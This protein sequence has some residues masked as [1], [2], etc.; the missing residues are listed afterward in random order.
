MGIVRYVL[1]ICVIILHTSVLT[2][3]DLPLN[4]YGSA[5]VGGFFALSGF[6]LFSSFQKKPTWRHYI[7]RR[8]RRILPPYFFI[9]IVCALSLSSI[10]TLSITEYFSDKGFWSYLAANLSFLNFLHPELPGVF[11]GP[12]FYNSAVNGSL[13]TMKGE[14]ICY[15]SIPFIFIMIGG[16]KRYAITILF[17][18]VVACLA[19]RFWLLHIYESSGNR[20]CLIFGN[21][22][23]SIFTFFFCGALVNVCYDKFLKYNRVIMILS[24]AIVLTADF[25]PLYYSIFRPFGLTGLV[26]WFSQVGK[27]GTFLK[28]HDDLSYDM[29]LFHYPLIQLSIYL[30]L[31]EKVSPPILLGIV[32]ITTFILSV[33]SWNL[34]GK[35]ILKRKRNP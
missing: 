31:P 9:V 26:L 33:F 2:G 14:W 11:Q 5:A 20:L 19:M 8:A 24:L 29:Y 1:S 12:D 10:S 28:N 13:W 32:M 3:V 7:E 30:G 22:F 6:L 27:W 16:K 18:L 25:N 35:P 4:S 15:L 34:I 17:S 23:A 21:Q